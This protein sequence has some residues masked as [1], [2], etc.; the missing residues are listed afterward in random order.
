MDSAILYVTFIVEGIGVLG[1]LLVVSYLINY[2]RRVH[3][4]VWMQLGKPSLEHPSNVMNWF[5]SFRTFHLTVYFIFL[6]GRHRTLNDARLTKLVWS[7]RILL[8]VGLILLFAR[9]HLEAPH[10]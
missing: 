4:D 2:L 3:T 8:V 9:K 6:S 7:A 5:R 1:Y 10:L